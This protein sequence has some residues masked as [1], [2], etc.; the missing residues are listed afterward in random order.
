MEWERSAPSG[1]D[2]LLAGTLDGVHC[3]SIALATPLH[4]T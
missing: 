2:P 1:A 3:Y 4:R